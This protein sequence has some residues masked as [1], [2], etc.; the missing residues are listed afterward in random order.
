MLLFVSTFIKRPVLTTVCSILIV[1]VGVISIPLLPISQLPQLANTQINVTAVN[2]GADAET[3]ETTVTSILEREINGVDNMRYISSN[4]ANNGVS[5]VSVAFPVNVD[6]DIAQVNVNNRVSQAASSLPDVV[7]QVGITVEASSPSI[8]LVLGFYSDTDQNNQ[9]IYDDVFIS[10]FLDLNVLDEITRAPGVGSV[11]I[12]GERR[13]A[14]RIWL[15]P[16][17]IAARGLVAQD[18]VAALRQQNIQVGAGKIGQAPTPPEQRFEIPLRAQGRLRDVSEFEELVVGVGN[19]GTL[20][21]I[22]DVGRVE[23]GAQDYNLDA[24]Y[25]NQ[26]AVGMAVYQRPGSNALETAEAVKSKMQE[27][28]ASFPPGVRYAIP[29]DTT[30]FV[31]AS[32]Q[33]VVITLLQTITLVILVIFVFLQDWRTTLIPTI[34]IPVAL[35]GSMAGLKAMGFELNTLTLFGCTLAAGLVVDD[36]IVIVEAVSSKIAQGMKPRQAALDAME[37]LTGAT[38]STSLV[39]LAVFIPVAFFPGTTGIIFQQFSLTITFAIICSTFN[40][41]SFSPTMAGVLLRPAKKTK[42]P[43]GWFFEKFNQGFGF[44]QNQYAKLIR[45]LVR[46]NTL[47]MG[48]FVGGLVLTVLMYGWVP[49][50]FVPQEDQGFFLVIMQGPDGV[51]LNYTA[52]AA[53]EITDLILQEP[54]VE[55]VFAAAGFGFDGL[56]PSQGVMFV[57]LKP[58]SERPTPEQSVYGVLGRINRALRGVTAVQAFAVNAA[59]V[60]GMG[61]TGGVEIQI[62]DRSG[63]LPIS[64]LVENGN[65]LLAQLN[66]DKYPAVGRAFSQFSASKGQKNIQV[67]R[68]RALA[69]NVNIS[70]VFSTLQIYFGSL[71]VNDFVLGQRQYRVVAQAE[72]EFRADPSDIGRLSVRSLDG[73]LIPLENLVKFEEIVGPEIITRFNLYRSMRIQADPAPGFSSG[74]VIAAIEQAAAETLDPS[75]GYAWQGSAL[76]EKAAGGAAIVIF[77]LGFV[78][79]FLVLSAQYESYIDPLIIMLAVPLA[80]LGALAAIWFRSNVLMAGGIWPVVNNDVYAQVALVMLIGLASKNSILIVEFANQLRDKGLNIQKAAA[81]AAEQR[82]RPIQMTAISSL[83]GFWPLVIASGAGASSR[84]SLGTAIFGG[85]LVGTLLSLLIT[86][87]LY[88][89]IKTLEARFLK[90]EKPQP[91]DSSGS[92]GSGP[93][94]S[95]PNGSGSNGS[96]TNG[97]QQ[98]QP[99][100]QPLDHTLTEN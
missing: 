11:T 71:Y 68:D 63:N 51:S 91:S 97:H 26:A 80:V 24:T 32:L 60:P 67:L 4:T 79:A 65:R 23:L 12:L 30:L 94:G 98:H 76:E 37:E 25:N 44:I 90:G 7:Q 19:D 28:S 82:F 72:S 9:P 96:Q 55:S 39:L 86:P 47:V 3:T 70:D 81:L 5:N 34:A 16:Q 77:G 99:Q 14:M 73:N 83:V 50:G 78:I 1:L 8:L 57:Q 43:L 45:F 36:A 20:I 13:Y 62:Q 59:P 42:G 18:V 69:L 52:D 87:N 61:S 89:A 21:K 84:W 88:I 33:E 29:Y 6:R 35:I 74:Q 22:T 100:S 40:A 58:W 53:E 75:F 85:M 49:T 2:I 64:A 92:N 27:L 10:N 41:L 38:I 46:I 15:N 66:S 56:N 95:G 54:E 93:N 17:K 31:Q 48:I